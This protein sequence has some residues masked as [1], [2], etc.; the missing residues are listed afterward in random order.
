M[1]E[2]HPSPPPARPPDSAT[3]LHQIE[4]L[5]ADAARLTAESA[6]L[7]EKAKALGKEA[8]RLKQRLRHG[9]DPHSE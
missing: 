1:N 3:L 7:R 2:T 8:D 9:D 6:A 4:Q 5:N